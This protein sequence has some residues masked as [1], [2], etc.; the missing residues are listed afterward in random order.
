VRRPVH[1][2]MLDGDGPDAEGVDGGAPAA[3]AETQHADPYYH[4][5]YGGNDDDERDLHIMNWAADV[6]DFQ[7]EGA[8][9]AATD[10][11]P[12]F[13]PADYDTS[14]CTMPIA[15]RDPISAYMMIDPV[16]LPTSGRTG[17]Q[18]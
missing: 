18:L 13:D 6:P 16:I 2:G 8:D 11:A 14:P 7:D 15:Y 17:S 10:D 12:E 5:S 1:P 9:D 3:A 4:T